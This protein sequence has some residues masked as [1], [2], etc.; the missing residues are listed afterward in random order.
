MGE[1]HGQE[2]RQDRHALRMVLDVCDSMKQFLRTTGEPG[3]GTDLSRDGVR[4]RVK[5]WLTALDAVV[6]QTHVR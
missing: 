6:E 5:D 3:P 1:L 4:Q 2:R